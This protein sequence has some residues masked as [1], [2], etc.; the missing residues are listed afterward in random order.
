MK[1]LTQAFCTAAARLLDPEV[2]RTP[3]DARL[4]AATYRRMVSQVESGV[5]PWQVTPPPGIPAE[6]S[7]ELLKGTGIHSALKQAWEI[8]QAGLGTA[9]KRPYDGH[10]P[11]LP[12]PHWWLFLR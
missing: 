8:S 5:K 1:T 2:T 11:N 9:A 12:E 6:R 7:R 4:S 3:E 10:N